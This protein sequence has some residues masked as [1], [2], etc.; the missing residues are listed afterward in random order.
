MQERLRL[1]PGAPTAR[2]RQR[3][4]SASAEGAWAAGLEAVPRHRR[5]T[6]RDPDRCARPG[7]RAARREP[8]TLAAGQREA[9]DQLRIGAARLL[10][11]ADRRARARKS[12]QLEDEHGWR[13]RH[14]LGA[15][16]ASAARVRARAA[17]RAAARPTSASPAS[18][19]PGRDRPTATPSGGW[20]ADRRRPAR[21]RARSSARSTARRSRGRCGASTGRGSTTGQGASGG[22]RSEANAGTYRQAPRRRSPTGRGRRL[23][24]RAAARRRP[25]L[26]RRLRGAGLDADV[27]S[28]W[29]RCR[30]SPRPPSQRWSR[31]MPGAARPG[32]RLS[33]RAERS[34]TATE[35][36]IQVLR[37]L[38][39]ETGV[40][41]LG[42][43]ETGDPAATRM[44]RGRRDRPH[45]PRRS[46]IRLAHEHRR[47]GRPDRRRIRELLDAGWPQVTSSPT[48]AGFLLPAGL[49]KKKA[50]AAVAATSRRR[51]GAPA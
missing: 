7:R 1:R 43:H 16:S 14:G 25:P 13:A 5:P 35:A 50:R 23:R 17:R 49:P 48:T 8:R 4:G 9:E 40:Q 11:D 30:R 20:Q 12:L 3:A 19:E 27:R 46:G 29:R 24:R 34:A 51:A 32:R 41:V 22:D 39:A 26:G 38:L 21:A 36:S 28:A 37:S 33:M 47:R 10:E 18:G 42:P 45:G 44:D 15:I 6:T 31:S 2:S